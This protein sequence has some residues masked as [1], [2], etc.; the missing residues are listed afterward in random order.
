MARKKGWGFEGAY[1]ERVESF[2]RENRIFLR[3]PF[4]FK[5]VF[6]KGDLIQIHPKVMVERYASL[7]ARRFI[8]MGAFSYCISTV[9]KPGVTIGRYC[10]IATNVRLMGDSHPTDRVSTHVF[11]YRPYAAELAMQDFGKMPDIVP[12]PDRIKPVT[13]GNDVWI[14]QDVLIKQGVN[15]GTGAIIAAG[16]VVTKDVQPYTVVGGV[17]AKII[18]PRFDEQLANK[19]IASEWWRYNYA[20]F[21]GL[22]IHEPEKF[23]DQLQ[24][25]VSDSSIRPFEPGFLTLGAALKAYLAERP[26]HLNI[27]GSI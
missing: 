16:S 21:A 17:P 25:K 6:N 8:S 1:D 11:S 3:H 18:R 14:G 15:I 24:E 27:A 9:L 22:A 20:D 2:F 12:H 4:K 26:Q 5:G 23:V 13:I 7:P 10:S 19:L